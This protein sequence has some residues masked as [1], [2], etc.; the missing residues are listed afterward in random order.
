MNGG[1]D[2]TTRSVKL[3][4]K[5]TVNLCSKMRPL[6]SCAEKDRRGEMW[7]KRSKMPQ[8]RPP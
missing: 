7:G 6:R 8:V 2:Q 3:G 4:G 1:I 5:E